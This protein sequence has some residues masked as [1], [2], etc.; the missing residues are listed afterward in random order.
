MKLSEALSKE[1]V[2][3]G[4][5]N[6]GKL[7][8]KVN[9]ST[10]IA[11]SA[12]LLILVVAF[13]IRVL[14]IRWEI[15]T[16]AVHLTEF[17]PFYQYSLTNYMVKNGLLSPY[18]P[19]LWTDTQRWAPE[20]I[21][22][23]ISLSS[24]PLTAAVLYDIIAALGINIDLMTF[25]AF[26]PVILGTL[27]VLI[28]YLIGK[29]IGG[30]AVGMLAALFLALNPSV[31]QRS[32][33]GWFD[34]EVC[35]FAF[36]LFIFFF[37]RAIEEER[38]IGS[39][40]KYSL[41][42]AVALAY[43]IM[44]WGAAYYLVDLAVLF[45]FVLLLMK[46]YSRRLF[47]AYSVSFGLGLLISAINPE[48]SVKYVTNSPILPVAGVFALLC[49][50]EI[51][52]N[53]TSAREKF[54][55]L[56][57][58]LTLLV[59]GFAALWTLGYIGS[60]AGKFVEVLNPFLRTSDPLVESV[61]EHRISAWGSIYYDLG[62]GIIFFLVGLFF[63]S[64]NLSTKNLFL[65]IF[66]LTSLY[67][68]SS[69][70]RLLFI[71]GFAF[72]LIASVGIVGILKPFVTLLKEPP[73]IT[74][75]RKFGL[76]HVGK[77]F[78][79]TAVFLIFLILMTN[80]AFS[81]QSGG[82]PNVYVQSYSP[83]TLTA[84]SLP[85]VPPQPV[86]E[87][88]DMLQYLNNFHDS[89]IVVCAWWDYGY[90]LAI[91]GNVTSLADNATI[92]STQIENVGYAFMANE[93]QSLTMLKTYKAKYILVFT[94]LGFAT[95]SGGST[96]ATG[97]GYGD[98]GKWTWMAR[99]SGE[100]SSENKAKYPGWDWTNETA[101]GALNST[102]NQWIW[103]DRGLNSTIYKLMTWVQYRWCY[104]N[105]VAYGPNNQDA[106]NVTEPIYFAEEYFAGLTLSPQD[107]SSKYG[108]LV[109]LVALYKIN[110]PD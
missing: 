35:M 9:H 105:N 3:N 29:D 41:G 57:A 55:S 65:V 94:T 20:G 87:W 100:S 91:L 14:P 45:V 66:G 27:A 81:P 36:L 101:F 93:T 19:T 53:L 83:T 32:N 60:V 92:N 72:A 46:R 6:L 51:A 59:G 68:A 84:G 25:C 10:I 42:G 56:A 52:R 21:N 62:I 99:I 47:F 54:L 74:T 106:A 12:L 108:G 73:K 16:G 17:D 67:F 26:V 38:P 24:L 82:V 90:W 76:Q 85:I 97:A 86:K 2:I 89:T 69:I 13:T 58:F 70:V 61:A 23:G 71:F 30:R 95:P 8:I 63:I 31:I 79:G 37:L 77:E 109:P 102:T 103:N 1:N 39:S 48:I 34:T 64:R 44:G 104:A 43:F 5:K 28:I 50:S 49:L 33:L 7:R 18:W 75:K 80:L 98:E 78:S 4:L 40:V 96:Y 107:A 11:Y 22:M 15:Q 110:Y 88:L